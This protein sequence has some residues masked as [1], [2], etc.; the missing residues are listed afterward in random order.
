[1]RSS[2]YTAAGAAD[3]LREF[4]GDRGLTALVVDELQLVDDR[5]RVV[6]GGLHGNHARRLLGRD[7]VGR[8]LEDE[9]LEV[10]HQQLVEHGLRIGL[11]QVIPVAE[12]DVFFADQVAVRP[13]PFLRDGNHG[14]VDRH[15][16]HGVDEAVREDVHLV[17]APFEV[18]VD[19]HLHRTD[20]AFER[21]TIAIVD[22]LGGDR[23]TNAAHETEALVADG[24]V[25]GLDASGSP[26]LMAASARV[27]AGS[28]S[29][30]RKAPCRSLSRR[31]RRA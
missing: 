12:A 25:L 21:R 8:G 13:L 15:L 24:A 16:F 28:C 10:T 23:A 9:R 26:F 17:E 1:M 14:G 4:L 2:R 27:A 7:V 5:E 3:D 29:G 11:V 22:D 30:R 20:Q 19:Q 18:T 31:H 6:R